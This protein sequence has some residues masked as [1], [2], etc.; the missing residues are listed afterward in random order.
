MAISTASRAVDAFCG[1]PFYETGTVQTRVV[2]PRGM[3]SWYEI[4]LGEVGDIS[5][6]TDLVVATTTNNDGTYPDTW[7][8]NTDFILE[9]ENQ[10]SNGVVGWPYERI[11]AIG[12]KFFP[13]RYYGFR[14]TVQ[15]TATWGWPAVP[16]PVIQATLILAAQFYKLGDA[17]FGVAGFG[18]F[19]V[20]RVR[21][22]PM[23][24]ALLAP[25]SKSSFGIA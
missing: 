21:D 18:D 17:P 7:T 19:G 16:L 22:N 5:T 2:S 24:Q 25:Y 12:N 11:R 13:V 1:R 23:A 10:I 3:G 14:Q 15:I 6:S 20:V 4:E 8:L 9:P